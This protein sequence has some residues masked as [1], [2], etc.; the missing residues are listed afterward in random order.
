MLDSSVTF[1]EIFVNTCGVLYF[2]AWSASFYPTLILNYKRK[3][4][5]GLS[6]DF[7][8]INPLG[9]LALTLWSWGVYFSPIARNQYRARHDGHEPQVSR[10]DLAFS[11][12]ALILSCITPAQVWYYN[13]HPSPNQQS[14][15][16]DERTALL[17]STPATKTDDALSPPGGIKPSVPCQIALAVMVVASF[18]YAIFVWVGKAEFLDWLYFA[19]SIKLAITC[20][21]FIPQIM[22]NWKLRSSAGWAIDQ[23]F[24]D[25]AGGILSL[26]ELIVSSIFIEHDPSGIVANPGKLGLAAVSMCYDTVFIL[27][28]YWFFPETGEIKLDSEDN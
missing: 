15:Q 16:D 17:P 21:K 24:C 11:L 10:S 2:L 19:A 28:K 6:P 20:V 18:I 7:V 25:L 4:T 23:I 9:F 5:T 3:R 26:T 8:W 12:H 22:L 27:Q 14:T 1:W 13:R